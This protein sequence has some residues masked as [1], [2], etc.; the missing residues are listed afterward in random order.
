MRL[1][2]LL[3]LWLVV[4]APDARAAGAKIGTDAETA[5]QRWSQ[6]KSPTRGPAESIGTTS[7]GCLQGA[8]A[9]PASGPGYDVFRTSRRRFFGHPD[10]VSFIKRLAKRAQKEHLGPLAVGDLSQPRGG[11]S[12]SGHK[13]HQTGLDVDIA[14]VHLAAKKT[15]R[16]GPAFR[17][18]LSA[19]AVVD[20]RT[21]R[22]TPA[23]NA[24]LGKLLQLTA[25]DP[26]VDRVFVHPA[27]KREL[28]A[29]EHDAAWLARL[30]PWWAHHDHFHVRLACPAASSDCQAQDPLP[31]GNACDKTLDW[32]LRDEARAAK[33][34]RTAAS[35]APVLPDRC[36]A[37]LR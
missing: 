9:L 3:L 7:A 31:P 19:P 13:S 14:Y 16:R 27:I 1:S 12:P 11:P 33:A 5:K 2:R 8:Q 21:A 22:L 20:L 25:M 30:R 34:Q 29:T 18:G 10:L 23:W 15:G 28:C 37:L 35:V 4:Q 26:A 32:W 24:R 17:E 36:A 6:Q